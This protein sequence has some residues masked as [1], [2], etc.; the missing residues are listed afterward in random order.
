M[1]TLGRQVLMSRRSRRKNRPFPSLPQRARPLVAPAPVAAPGRAAE[2]PTPKLGQQTLSGWQYLV[3]AT[4]SAWPAEGEDRELCKYR[5]PRATL[6]AGGLS[7]DFEDRDT[8][9]GISTV[10]LKRVDP[11]TLD[12]HFTAFGG[13]RGHIHCRI[14]ESATGFLLL[15]RWTD[16]SGVWTWMAD[17][18]HANS[19]SV[20]NG[21]DGSLRLP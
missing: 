12:G 15:G 6:D 16:E 20:H 8:P 4:L 17:L 5:I 14:F 1:L 2:A 7:L 9:E 3:N 18:R 10:R 13:E 21:L 19:A 11:C